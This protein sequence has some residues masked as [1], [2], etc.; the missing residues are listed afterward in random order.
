WKLANGENVFH[1]LDQKAEDRRRR[2]LEAQRAAAA[3]D[4]KSVA[5]P[6][7]RRRSRDY[8]DDDDDDDDDSDAEIA[9]GKEDGK[10]GEVKKVKTK[11]PKKPK[12]TVAE[13]AA[14]IDIT[15]LA[16][17]LAEVS[18]SYG[19]QQEIQLMRFADYFGR[20]FSGVPA[21]QFPWLKIFRESTLA[22]MADI[23]LSHISDAVYKTSVDWINQHSIEALGSFV[24]WCL[25]STI[26]DLASQQT[27]GKGSKKGV[28]QA[29]SKSKVISHFDCPFCYF[30]YVLLNFAALTWS[31][32]N[33]SECVVQQTFEAIYPTLKEVAL[34]GSPG[35]KAM[36]QVSQQIFSFAI[37]A[38]GE[39]IPELSKEAAGIAIWC[40]IQNADCCK[41]WDKVYR[42]NI[43][44]SVVI[45]KKLSE[46][47]KVHS[48]KLSPL[49]PLRETIKNFRRKNEKEMVG[50][51]DSTDQA[52]YRDAD[53]Y[54]KLVLGKLSRGNGCMKSMAFLAIALAVGAALLSSP[55][56][57][58]LDL[59]KLSVLFSQS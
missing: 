33:F 16:A 49:E 36:K 42:D 6:R 26:L 58:S 23:P 38:A 5:P 46:E 41:L 34:A 39:S 37:K 54:C 17:F 57:E 12:V 18:G 45:L 56:M 48:N 51:A 25:D 1:S 28:Q 19:D 4:P 30:L 24:L 27:G 35:S 29:S 2:I 32:F 8:D 52:V 20:A 59:K 3:S 13:A 55:N 43:E 50:G 14:K 15:D 47:W 10:E 21:S 40:L 11:K 7:S 44:A 9:A 53:K 31:I 22:K